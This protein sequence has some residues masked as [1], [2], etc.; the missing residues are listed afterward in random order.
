MENEWISIDGQ[1]PEEGLELE[2]QL[3]DG[4]SITTDEIYYIGFDAKSGH[5]FV[6]NDFSDPIYYL[7]VTHWRYKNESK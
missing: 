7:N 1:A 4:N 6:N 3:K 5:K 2:L